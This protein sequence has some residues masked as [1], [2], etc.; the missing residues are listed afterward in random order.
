MFLA[1]IYSDYI[2][3]PFIKATPTKGHPFYQETFGHGQVS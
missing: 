3:P 1:H 2:N